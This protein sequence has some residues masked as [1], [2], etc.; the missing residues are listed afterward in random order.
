MGSFGS[1][2]LKSP[3]EVFDTDFGSPL[4]AGELTRAG[5]HGLGLAAEL[6]AFAPAALGA[7][8]AQFEDARA[9]RLGVLED[10]ARRPLLLTQ[11]PQ[12]QVL[13]GDEVV[14]EAHGL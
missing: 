7:R 8:L 4:F 14:L 3:P 10:L 13:A 11:Q 6:G 5:Q 2:G 9:D 1:G 12:Q